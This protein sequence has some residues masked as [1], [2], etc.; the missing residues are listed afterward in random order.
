M[1][2]LSSVRFFSFAKAVECGRTARHRKRVAN[3]R[4]RDGVIA[5]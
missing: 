5:G 3:V 1:T 4:M 2:T